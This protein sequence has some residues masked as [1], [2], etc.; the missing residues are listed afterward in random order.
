MLWNV[1]MMQKHL[2]LNLMN[3]KY[4]NNSEIESKL[5]ILENSKFFDSPRTA[6]E[7]VQH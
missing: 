6:G 7:T 3:Q 5:K 2:N 1:W 4:I